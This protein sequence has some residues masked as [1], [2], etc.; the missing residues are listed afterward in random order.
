MVRHIIS[1]LLIVMFLFSCQKET[2]KQTPPNVIV[3]MTDDQG[4][5]DLH[6]HG[7]D[8]IATP[9]LDQFAK[10]GIQFD[11]FYVSPVC[12]PTRAS[13]LTGRY[14][15]R[16]GTS[17][18]THRKEV[19]RSEEV[20]MAEVFKDAGYTTGLFGKWH[21]GSQYPHNPNGQGF[22][23]FYGFAAGHWNNYFDTSL[24]H[25]GKPVKTEG[26]VIDVL[27]D[28][29]IDFIT[30][31]K[32]SPFLCY[33]PYNTPHSP[34][35]VPNKYFDK[36]KKMGLTDKNACVYGMVENIDDNF[37]R[38]L[39]TLENLKLYENTIVLFLTDNGPNGK[40]YNGNMKGRKGK[41]DE[42]GV[43]VPLLVQ[44]KNHLPKGKTIKELT[45]HIDILPTLMDL[46]AIKNTEHKPF[47]GKSVVPLL[48]EANPT[49]AERN[50]YSIQNDGKPK[51]F[52][53]SV[54]NNQYRLVKD[55][56]EN[57]L[58]Y[59][60]IADPSQTTDIATEKPAI[61]KV[62]AEKLENWYKEVTKDGIEP[63]L[64]EV[65]H[66]ESLITEL[67]APE[68]KISGG[69]ITFEGGWGWAN[70]WVNNWTSPKDLLAWKIKVV[71]AGTY[72]LKV[73]Y[74]AKQKGITFKVSNRLKTLESTT[75]K[76]NY[77]ANI[78]SPDRVKRGEAYERIFAAEQDLG[79]IQLE[80]EVTSLTLQALGTTADANLIVKGMVIEKVE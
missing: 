24:E 29:A 31:N 13:L 69:N 28:K 79:T 77:P 62:L 46:C 16:T 3:I 58:L 33:I 19:M 70:D 32:E 18:V 35:Q 34:F 75:Q 67:P 55:R 41:V 21:N 68:A 7:N 54:R 36:Y 66:T 23:E 64:V 1:L 14:H 5:G 60:M 72:Q 38:V 2:P 25:N 48:K 27:T 59:D 51:D 6:L 37:G 63:S 76:A 43:R 56:D 52:P 71:T 12:A 15:L 42:G 78:P 26:Y 22:E 45:S 11:R 80:S 8:S 44:W 53:A 9:N 74:G 47:D 50:I 39:K 20:T 30:Q 57:I 61:T 65:G 40:R 49:W 17:W 4:Y 73:L 10:N